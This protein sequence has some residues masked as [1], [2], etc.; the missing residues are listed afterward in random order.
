MVKNNYTTRS[1]LVK[2]HPTLDTKKK[3]PPKRKI[4]APGR[5]TTKGGAQGGVR[6]RGPQP[7]GAPPPGYPGMD[8]ITPLTG[9]FSD[10]S[11]QGN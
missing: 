4:S 5:M 3:G 11:N 1:T 9:A 6:N 8:F 10:I 7:Q 2:K